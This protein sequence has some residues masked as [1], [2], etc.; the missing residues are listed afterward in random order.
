MIAQCVA[1][2]SHIV[3][4][5]RF[6]IKGNLAIGEALIRILSSLTCVVFIYFYL[7]I[8]SV[9]AKKILLALFPV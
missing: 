1:G 6:W 2:G 8:F 4:F 7:F 9:K 5:L 3:P